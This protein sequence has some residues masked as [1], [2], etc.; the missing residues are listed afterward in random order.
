MISLL[1]GGHVSRKAV[2]DS[3]ASSPCFKPKRKRPFQVKLDAHASEDEVTG[4]PTKVR[5]IEK[6]RILASHASSKFG[7]ERMSK[8]TQGLLER[9]SLEDHALSAEGADISVGSL[10][11][12]TLPTVSIDL[13]Y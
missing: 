12:G 1:G 7:V 3:F 6:K 5:A 9:Q 11:N 13:Q 8:A 2:G 10:G 4:S